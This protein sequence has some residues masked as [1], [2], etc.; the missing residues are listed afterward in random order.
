MA[1]T[2]HA[3]LRACFELG[4]QRLLVHEQLAV[5]GA[6]SVGRV[7]C[8]GSS[9]QRSVGENLDALCPHAPFGERDQPVAQRFEL[10]GGRVQEG[11]D[12]QR[13]FRRLQPVDIHIQRFGIDD[14]VDGRDAEQ[15]VQMCERAVDGVDLLRRGWF[16]RGLA[17]NTASS[18]MRPLSRSIKRLGTRAGRGAL[19]WQR[20][21]GSIRGAPPAGRAR[22]NPAAR[23]G[24]VL[25]RH[26]LSVEVDADDRLIAA[27]RAPLAKAFADSAAPAWWRGRSAAL[28]RQRQQMEVRVDKAGIT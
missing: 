7:Q 22:L 17:S 25:S 21:R 27:M 26:S 10:F 6:V 11:V 24:S 16:V 1:C 18:T 5:P 20:R 19:C 14:V 28:V 9:S 4:L 15:R 2:A 3:M 13:A 23:V 12:A 8:G